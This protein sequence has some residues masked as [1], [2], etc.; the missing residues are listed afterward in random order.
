VLDSG[1]IAECGPHDE[2]LRLG[3]RYA[4]FHALREN[5]RGRRIPAARN[6]EGD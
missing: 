3:G 1:R 6:T 5:A 4:T 2:L